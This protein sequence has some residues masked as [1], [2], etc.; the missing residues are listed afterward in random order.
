MACDAAKRRRRP[1]HGPLYHRLDDDVATV[2]GAG[3]QAADVEQGAELVLDPH[4]GVDA[5]YVVIVAAE[6]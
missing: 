4:G 2:L 5:E 3:E 6:V 1:D